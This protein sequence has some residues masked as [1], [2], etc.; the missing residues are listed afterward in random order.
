M[1]EH[2]LDTDFCVH[3]IRRRRPELLPRLNAHHGRLAVSAVTVM[4]LARGAEGSARPE[5]NRELARAFLS[6][7]EVLPFDAPAAE[8]A[9]ALLARLAGEGRAIGPYDTQIA[10]HALSL[11]LALVTGNLREFGRVEGLRCEDWAGA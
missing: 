7:V 4:E 8:A 2:L 11:G 1:L 6:L 9:G 3:V 10:G 5:A